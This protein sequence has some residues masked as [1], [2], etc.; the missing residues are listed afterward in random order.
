MKKQLLKLTIGALL[1]TKVGDDYSENIKK[2]HKSPAAPE[3]ILASP[4]QTDTLYQEL[5]NYHSP[6]RGRGFVGS[7]DLCQIY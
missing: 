1:I 7:I 6:N 5:V 2:V 4:S 3:A